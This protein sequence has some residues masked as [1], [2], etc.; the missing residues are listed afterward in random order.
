MD[1]KTELLNSL[2]NWQCDQEEYDNLINW[3]DII[4]DSQLLIK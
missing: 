4:T 1:I 2:N 3:L